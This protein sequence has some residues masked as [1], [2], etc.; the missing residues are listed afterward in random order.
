MD[1][2]QGTIGRVFS[3]RFDEGD[4]FLAENYFLEF[5]LD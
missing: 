5:R 4:D 2:R 3:V 1:Y